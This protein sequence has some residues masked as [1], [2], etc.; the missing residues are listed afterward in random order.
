MQSGYILFI[1][2]GNM[3][4]SDCFRR[5]EKGSIHIPLSYCASQVNKLEKFKTFPC[6]TSLC[7]GLHIS[8][9]VSTL[10]LEQSL[11]RRLGT[12]LVN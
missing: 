3:H 12:V 10:C 5:K 4:D 2:S 8:M 11:N 6:F 1:N 7:K 9:N